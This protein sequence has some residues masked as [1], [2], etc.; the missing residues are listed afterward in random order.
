MIDLCDWESFHGWKQVSEKLLFQG[1]HIKR[2]SLI[3]AANRLQKA[4]FPSLPQEVLVNGIS[5]IIM[6]IPIPL[7]VTPQR[8]ATLFGF[9][10]CWSD[11]DF[12]YLDS[13]EKYDHKKSVKQTCWKIFRHMHLNS[14]FKFKPFYIN[15]AKSQEHI[16]DSLG[17]HNFRLSETL[18][19]LIYHSSMGKKGTSLQSFGNLR[20]SS[21]Y[22]NT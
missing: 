3:I 22:R 8:I 13:M 21:V 17:N 16:K 7:G 20:Q 19:T 12:P 14:N 10:S 2:F 5:P 4:A 15:L 6:I 9:R 1:I 11:A 18:H